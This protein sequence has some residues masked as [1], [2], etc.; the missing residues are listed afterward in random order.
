[1]PHEAFKDIH[2][3]AEVHDAGGANASTEGLGEF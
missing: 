1:M 3:T 2:A